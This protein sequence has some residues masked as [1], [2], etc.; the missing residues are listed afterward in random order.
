MPKPLVIVFTGE[1]NTGGLAYNLSATADEKLPQPRLKILNN[2][3]LLFESLLIGT[4]NITDHEDATDGYGLTLSPTWASSRHGWEVPLSTAIR[5]NEFGQRPVYLIKTGQGGSKA[6]EWES[7]SG[8]RRMSKFIARINAM[9]AIVGNQFDVVIWMSI[10][11]NDAINNGLSYRG[12]YNAKMAIYLANIR[13]QFPGRR[14]P[15]LMTGLTEAYPEY[16]EEVKRVA[17]NNGAVFVPTDGASQIDTEG[18]DVNHWGYSGVQT[19][20]N[21]LI[22][23][24]KSLTLPQFF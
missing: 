10:G 7:L 8:A 19:I 1:S 13:A 21:R 22:K 20:G 15:I 16:T 9:A 14:C 18:G 17:L 23:L 11:I 2:N 5:R 24:T 4:N 12:T 6:A 3:T